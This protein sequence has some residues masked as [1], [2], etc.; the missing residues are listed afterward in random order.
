M[1]S[2]YLLRV[3]VR[4]TVFSKFSVMEDVP[5]LDEIDLDDLSVTSELVGWFCSYRGLDFVI[6]VAVYYPF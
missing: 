6:G 1:S 4:C 5:D 2:S 3:D